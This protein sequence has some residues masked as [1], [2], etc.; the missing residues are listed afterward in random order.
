MKV[1]PFLA[2]LLASTVSIAS[3]TLA[4]TTSAATE[5]PVA[6]RTVRVLSPDVSRSLVITRMPTS[7]PTPFLFGTYWNCQDAGHGF[8]RCRLVLV[9]CNQD[10]SQ[11]A[12]A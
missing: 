12:E 4:Q 6:T 1:N 11:C 2:A 7:Q 9:V 5:S 10:Q 8:N 3:P